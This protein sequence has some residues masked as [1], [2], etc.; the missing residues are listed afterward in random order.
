MKAKI[1]IIKEVELDKIIV[2]AGIRYYA[3]CEYSTDNGVT[4]VEP[5]DPDDDVFEKQ[6]KSIIPNIIKEDIGYKE[7]DY[8]NLVI[9]V[10]TGQVENWPKGLCLSTHFKVC[11]DGLYQILDTEK[12]VIWDSIK[13][14][15]YYVPYFLAI[16]DEGYGDYI[17]ININGDGYINNWREC[18][19]PRISDLLEESN[20]F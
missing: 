4:W 12:N 9:D 14:K 7:A 17:Y 13:T 3:D 19:I 20:D 1:K 18:A 2:K 5:E 6:S 8:W 15:Y 10:N 16:E 11:D